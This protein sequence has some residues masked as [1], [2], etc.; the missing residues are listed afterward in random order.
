MTEVL[1][2]KQKL[3]Q[4][5]KQGLVL[6]IDETL[7]WTIGY[8]VEKMQ[9]KFGNPEEL[10]VQEMVRKY[11]YV[12]NIPYWQTEE[13]WQWIKDA[14]YSDSLQEELALIENANHVVQ[15]INKVIPI[16][17]YITVRPQEVENGTRRWLSKHQFPMTDI[18]AR[19][20]TVHFKDGT[21]WK[22]DILAFLYPEVTGIIDD[23]PALI[24]NLPA[25]YRGTIF[26][27]DANLAPRTDIKV[28]PCN[29][30]KEVHKKVRREYKHD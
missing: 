27:Y 22:A 23:N 4:E 28:T 20:P 25:D 9:I 30:W 2:L 14:V 26:L 5:H 16:V 21:K 19:P 10:S 12:Q 1:N 18:I 6:D 15:K 3:Q 24:E 8:W 13:A 17:G 7:S 29:N 11:R